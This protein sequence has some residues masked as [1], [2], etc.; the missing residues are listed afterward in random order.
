[1][2]NATLSSNQTQIRGAVE[3]VERTRKKKIGILGLSFKA[4]TDDVR[5]SP[6]VLLAEALV[7]KG[8][9]V[10]IFDENVKLAQLTGANRSYLERELPHIA[11]LM[12]ESL[13]QALAASEV[14]VI[15]NGSPAFRVVPALLR[16]SQILIDLVGITSDAHSLADSSGRKESTHYE[17]V[18][19]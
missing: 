2:L 3:R 6:V 10:S 12:C 16:E 17:S 4:G 14:V 18:S 19:R 13:E 1:V 5:E 15:G 11:N 7:G 8:H 9:Q